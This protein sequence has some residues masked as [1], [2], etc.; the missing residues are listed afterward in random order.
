MTDGPDPVS[1][2]EMELRLLKMYLELYQQHFDLLI[3]GGALYFA[4]L[5]A[6]AG[7]VFLETT[8]VMAQIALSLMGATFS[9]VLIVAC[10]GLLSWISDLAKLVHGIQ[11]RLDTPRFSFSGAQTVVRGLI[12]GACIVLLAAVA[13]AIRV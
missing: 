1:K 6:I 12:S 5:G 9:A 4:I 7:Y 8:S 3:K 2:S 10:V 13:N 11:E